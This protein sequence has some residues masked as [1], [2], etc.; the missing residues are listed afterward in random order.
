MAFEPGLARRHHV[1]TVLLARVNSPFS[2]WCHEVSRN[3][4]RYAYG[5]ASLVARIRAACASTVGVPVA[6][7]RLGRDVTLLPKAGVP[8]DRC[9]L[10]DPEALRRLAARGTDLDRRNDAL[11]QIRRQG[12]RHGDAPCPNTASLNQKQ[13][14]LPLRN[15]G[16]R[17][18]NRSSMLL[19]NGRLRRR[20]SIPHSFLLV[21]GERCEIRGCCPSGFYV[22]DGHRRRGRESSGPLR[23]H[24]VHQ[25]SDRTQRMIRANPLSKIH[26][27]KQR[28]APATLSTHAMHSALITSSESRTGQ[29]DVAP[30]S[31][32]DFS[33]SCSNLAE[34]GTGGSESRTVY[35]LEAFAGFC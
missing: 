18:G 27:G 13:R 14:P 35:G 32:A 19:K 30:K 28:A 20:T 12:G 3:S 5:R 23:R 22:L 33:A 25:S 8:G 17:A 15:A 11:A 21:G 7:H 26:V 31:L 24:L 6:S 16:Q 34:P 2:A 29:H 1:G 4:S 10:V 9:R